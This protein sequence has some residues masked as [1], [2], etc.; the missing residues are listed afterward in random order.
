MAQKSWWGW[1]KSYIE[2]INSCSNSAMI[3]IFDRIVEDLGADGFYKK[4]YIWNHIRGKSFYIYAARY[5]VFYMKE[6]HRPLDEISIDYR[7]ACYRNTQTL[8]RALLNSTKSEKTRQTFIR[9][10]VKD[11]P[12][13]SIETLPYLDAER[14]TSIIQGSNK[15][16]NGI[17]TDSSIQPFISEINRLREENGDLIALTND[18]I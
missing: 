6:A 9:Q 17:F 3:V 8:I 5:V 7:N 14:I 18:V 12:L 1:N 13:L 16:Y 10:I 15:N 4:R 2:A 11:I